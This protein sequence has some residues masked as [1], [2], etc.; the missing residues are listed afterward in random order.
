MFNLLSHTL[1][2]SP[3]RGLTASF[4]RRLAVGLIAAP[5]VLGTVSVTALVSAA[6]ASAFTF[7]HSHGAAG[8]QGFIPGEDGETW[9]G[10]TTKMRKGG[11]TVLVVDGDTVSLILTNPA[12]DLKVDRRPPA[13]VKVDGE[14][15]VGNAVVTHRDIIEISNI[16]M[17]VIKSL[18]DGAEAV[19]DIDDGDIV[20]TLD[21]HGLSAAM[22]EALK[23]YGSY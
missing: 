9:R 3:R 23:G 8:W 21:L 22:L 4:T 17:K 2:T 16:S 13:S 7:L 6:P 20:W 10:A 15:F 1:V 5:L 11:T 14:S 12:W 18:A 19:V